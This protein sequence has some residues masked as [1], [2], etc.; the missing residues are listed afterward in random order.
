MINK[1]T[2]V[3]NKDDVEAI[4]QRI[5]EALAREQEGRIE[6]ALQIADRAYAT[7]LELDDRG[8]QL[9]ALVQKA[10]AFDGRQ[11]AAARIE[12]EDLYHQALD[13]ADADGDAL[14]VAVIWRRLALL[15]VRMDS[16]MAEALA[17]CENHAAAVA[18]L[19]VDHLERSRNDHL[20]CEIHYRKARYSDAERHAKQAVDAL[21]S[22]PEQERALPPN[23][24]LDLSRYRVAL[25]KS[26]EAQGRIEEAITTYELAKASAG[27]PL[28]LSHADMVT[29]LMNYGLALKKQGKLRHARTVLETA[30]R[31][32]PP[33]LGPTLDRGIIHTF[34]SDLSY[35]EPGKADE[36]A[37][38]GHEAR[39]IYEAIGAPDHRKAEACTNIGNAEMKRKAFGAARAWYEKAL[40][41]RRASLDADHYQLGVNEGS[42][43]EAL[44]GL[45]SYEEAKPHVKEARRI[46]ED[47]SF[48][49]EARQWILAVHAR[50]L[51]GLQRGA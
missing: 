23:Q 48:N 50:V 13:L 24:Q 21:A 19:P 40:H 3:S 14:H 35:T 32:L 12:A 37:H 36:A 49:P 46:L 29:L 27:G 34:L 39:K 44:V 41:L 8:L 43:A 38:H 20:Y 1:E 10:R 16:E 31:S 11:T 7:A 2:A 25:A 28:G 9:R 26:L 6:E 17:R 51:D 22:T 5:A 15:A 33:E 42:L 47:R 18:R 4:Q 45:E 30:L